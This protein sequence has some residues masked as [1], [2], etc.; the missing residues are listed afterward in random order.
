[1]F[2]HVFTLVPV[3][4]PVHGVCTGAGVGENAC[5][6]P[7]ARAFIWFTENPALPAL[8]LHGTAISWFI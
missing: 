6:H 1:M 4:I 7:F 8:S 3:L 5:T 2:T